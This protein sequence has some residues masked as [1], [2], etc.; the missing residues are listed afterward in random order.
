M[1]L[2]GSRAKFWGVSSFGRESEKP[3]ALQRKSVGN[4]GFANFLLSVLLTQ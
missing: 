2:I 1:T 3:I 4:A